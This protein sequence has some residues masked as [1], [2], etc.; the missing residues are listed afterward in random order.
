MAPVLLGRFASSEVDSECA[1]TRRTRA[2]RRAFEHVFP[3]RDSEVPESGII[4]DGLKLCF[5][6]SAG[7]SPGPELDLFLSGL[8]YFLLHQDVADL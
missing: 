7:D 1:E 2:L 8:E 3:P 6:Q 5:Q 4:D